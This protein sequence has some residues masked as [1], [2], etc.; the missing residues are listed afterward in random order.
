MA[1][2]HSLL[3]EDSSRAVTIEQHALAAVGWNKLWKQK[4]I[5]TFNYCLKGHYHKITVRRRDYS[6]VKIV[7]RF[8]KVNGNYSSPNKTLKIL[9]VSAFSLT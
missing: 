6:R 4:L 7:S 8:A 1:N 2:I 9:Q 3:F 5:N